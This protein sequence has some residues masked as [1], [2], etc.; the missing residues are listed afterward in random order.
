MAVRAQTSIEFLLILSAVVLVVLAGVM[1]LSEIMK[2]QQG[3]YSAAQSGVGN[4]SSSMLN[5]LSNE[6]FGTGFYPV[7]GGFGN[8]TNASLVSLELIKNEPYF[9]NQPAVIQLNAWNNY[10]DPMKVPKLVIWIVNS[11]GN[12]TPLSPSEEDNVTV[13]ASHTLTAT[14][15]PTSPGVYNVS[16][17]AQD[18]NGNTLIN[19]NTNQ[20]VLVRT[21]FTVLD[22]RPPSN[23]II[24]TFNIEKD[25][26]A[27]RGLDYEE[28]FSLPDDAVIYSAVL[29][30]ED[31]HRYEDKTAGAQASYYLQQA[32]V[33]QNPYPGVFM[34][35]VKSSTFSSQQGTVEIP[36][37]SIITNANYL[38][39]SI[40]GSMDVYANGA[41]NPLPSIDMVKPGMNT[42][43]ISMPYTLSCETSPAGYPF[44]GYYLSGGDATLTISY[45]AP[46]AKSEPVGDL[47][48][49]Q[50]NDQSSHSAF[51]VEDVSAYVRHG[52]NNLL[53]RNVQGSFHYKLVV[54]YA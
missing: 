7:S 10:P 43:S 47:L 5:Y 18:D 1:S 3:A 31:A 53:F 36:P 32:Y 17:V 39:N 12:E 22:A 21:N 44:E 38:R 2:M 4:A 11:S 35:Q 26:V 40:A 37:N 15:I 54:N 33:C 13:I 51:A 34:L 14:F 45:Y 48:S 50:L 46:S 29:E 52:T 9:L 27:Q 20:S 30:I 42:I 8:Y 6:S 28:I 24:K 41:K 16:A 25:V 23:G 19:P 49:T